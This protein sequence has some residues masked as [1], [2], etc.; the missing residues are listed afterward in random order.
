M[1]TLNESLFHS[2][3]GLSHQSFLLDG[4]FVFLGQYLPYFMVLLALGWIFSFESKRE[5]W[6]VFLEI[7]I[8]LI[9]SRGIIAEVFHFFYQH[10]RPMDALGL[11][12]LLSEHGNSFPSGH[13]SFM[14]ALSG[15]ML[16]FSWRWGLVY[17][18]LSLVNGFARVVAGV[19]WPLDILGG[20]VV[21]LVSAI[22][23]HL[24]LSKYHPHKKETED[25]LASAQL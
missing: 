7:A 1:A 2:L 11:A 6:F 23:I 5:R 10:P 20:M 12:A 13:A 22:L 16:M 19:H 21:G 17:L 14:F 3:F 18:G 24:L 4:F 15:G 9:L 25:G 8:I